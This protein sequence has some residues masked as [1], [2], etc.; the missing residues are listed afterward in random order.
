MLFRSKPKHE[1]N[2]QAG[3]IGRNGQKLDKRITD[4]S[5]QY[6]LGGGVNNATTIQQITV[7]KRYVLGEVTRG[8]LMTHLVIRMPAMHT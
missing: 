7:E 2:G 6:S 5:R 1:P 4:K 3:C 8:L